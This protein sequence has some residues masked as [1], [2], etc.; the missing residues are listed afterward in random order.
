MSTIHE[1]ILKNC[2]YRFILKQKLMHW[3]IHKESH[4]C[5]FTPLPLLPPPIVVNKIVNMRNRV[6]THCYYS[7]PIN[8]WSISSICFQVMV[9][10]WWCF[11]V[12]RLLNVILW[13][14]LRVYNRIRH[15]YN[16]LPS[17]IHCPLATYHTF[18][19]PDPAHRPYSLMKKAISS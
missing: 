14:L 9:S 3:V 11:G 1:L 7:Y 15:F 17:P 6:T 13:Y 18:F 10:K 19:P 2:V 12:N 16:P 8:R 4:G 5:L